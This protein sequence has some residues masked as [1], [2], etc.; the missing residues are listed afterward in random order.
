LADNSLE[1]DSPE[2]RDIGFFD[3]RY[4]LTNGEIEEGMG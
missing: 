2:G 1:W 4:D 3:M